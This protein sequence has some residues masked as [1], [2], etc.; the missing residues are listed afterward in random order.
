MSFWTMPIA[1]PGRFEEGVKL[2]VLAYIGATVRENDRLES[3]LSCDSHKMA[4]DIATVGE[5]VR[6]WLR[7]WSRN[8]E[9]FTTVS[10]P[11]W[12]SIRLMSAGSHE[13]NGATTWC[14]PR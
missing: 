2:T 4:M 5:T 8:I 1:E 3:C 6:A 10:P 7:P 13:A 14:K 12:E 11:R 9:G